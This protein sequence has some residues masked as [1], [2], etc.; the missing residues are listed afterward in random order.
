MEAQRAAKYLHRNS[1]TKVIKW[2]LV[3]SEASL[4]TGWFGITPGFPLV[5]QDYTL[6]VYAVFKVSFCHLES[7]R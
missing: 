1:D 2:R 6:M 5:T 7:E 3:I 4:L